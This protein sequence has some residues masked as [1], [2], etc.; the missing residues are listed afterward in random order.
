MY[1]WQ[2][3]H[4]FWLATLEHSSI[5]LLMLSQYSFWCSLM[6]N[7]ISRHLSSAPH[8]PNLFFCSYYK[9][10]MLHNDI[11]PKHPNANLKVK[12]VNK[13]EEFCWFKFMG[14]HSE[15]NGT[16]YKAGSFLKDKISFCTSNKCVALNL[17]VATMEAI[18]VSLGD[19]G[20]ILV[21]FNK[22]I[23]MQVVCLSAKFCSKCSKSKHTK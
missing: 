16:L 4:G 8:H 15:L 22:R 20:G 3:Y 14:W 9:V 23:K 21:T 18:S 6:L 12:K 5:I 10:P 7:T 13:Q 2:L 1:L 19:K 17:H 11:L